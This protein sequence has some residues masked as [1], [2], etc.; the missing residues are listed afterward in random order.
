MFL[1]ILFLKMKDGNWNLQICNF[2]PENVWNEIMK[3]LCSGIRGK[4]N[5]FSPYCF[6]S[7]GVEVVVWPT[8]QQPFRKNLTDAPISPGEVLTVT[9]HSAA[10]WICFVLIHSSNCNRKWGGWC[11]QKGKE[12]GEKGGSG[13]SW[14]LLLSWNYWLKSG[15]RQTG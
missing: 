4:C 14:C 1:F 7:M 11:W 8:Q 9:C 2:Y 3:I 15:K 5:Y 12:K 10:E 13:D 6:S